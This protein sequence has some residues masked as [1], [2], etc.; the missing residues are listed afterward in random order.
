[1]RRVLY[2]LPL[3]LFALLLL[4]TKSVESAGTLHIEDYDV[5]VVVNQDST[6]DVSEKISYRA[7]GEFH[8]I[9]REITLQ[10]DEAFSKCKED[11][12][13]QCGGF[14]Y[15]VITG[16]Y[17]EDGNKLPEASYSID[18]IYSSYEDRLRV[19]WEYAPEGRLFSNDLFT[20]TVEYKVYGGLGY[21]EDYDLFYWDV[22]YPD[23]DYKIENAS[24]SIKFP[25]DIDFQENDLKVLTQTGSYNYNYDYDDFNYTLDLSAKDLSS[26]VDFTVLL[27]FPKDIVSE[28]ATLNLKLDP[29]DQQIEVDGITIYGFSDSISG[30]PPGTHTL[31][32]SKDG[33]KSQN[34][35]LSFEEGEIK[36]LEVKLEMT[37][38]QK[39]LY[40]GIA[41]LNVFSCF[42]GV[43]IIGLVILGYLRKGRD[44]G[45]RKTIVP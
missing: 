9:Y 3:S 1:M 34:Y 26:Y 12:T 14:S 10:D 25:E 8:R 4:F 37:D 24:F 16:V 22:F 17:D 40:I 19:E 2:I 18:N 35:T 33:Y 21:F 45:G 30:I 13:L 31:I 39:L 44:V 15:I 32:F 5:K 20:W 27:K 11:P 23:R 29:N 28:Y 43:V 36:D 41:L 38:A 42:G 7:T 6:F